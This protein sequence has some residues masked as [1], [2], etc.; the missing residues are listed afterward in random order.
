MSYED[1][2]ATDRVVVLRT[3]IL[4]VH[5]DEFRGP[6][7][8]DG[9]GALWTCAHVFSC[10][11]NF[12]SLTWGQGGTWLLESFG[13]GSLEVRLADGNRVFFLWLKLGHPSICTNQV[14]SDA[15]EQDLE[16]NLEPCCMK[17]W[18]EWKVLT[19]QELVR[20]SWAD[21]APQASMLA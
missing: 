7:G 18:T 1:R 6:A 15:M 19:R 4:Y 9:Q 14:G 21:G 8:L 17:D 13:S 16:A 10:L 12:I 2:K 5:L 20:R 11:F 3:Y